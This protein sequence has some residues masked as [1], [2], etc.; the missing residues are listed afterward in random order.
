MQHQM[1]HIENAAICKYE[2][3]NYNNCTDNKINYY[4]SKVELY[5]YTIDTNNCESIINNEFVQNISF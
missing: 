3:E 1:Q 2:Q 5:N 4:L